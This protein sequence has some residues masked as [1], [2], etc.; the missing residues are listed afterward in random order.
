M[1]IEK[2]S[3]III[4]LTG[5]F[6]SGCSTL[7]KA[8][9]EL[10]FKRFSLSK[11]VKEEW[12]NK[13]KNKN[14]DSAPR[15]ELQN[16]G[17]NLRKRYGYDFLAKE[18]SNR[19]N[20]TVKGKKEKRVVFDSIRNTDEI[21]WLRDNNPN[22]YLIAVDCSRSIRWERIKQKKYY[23][24]GLTESDFEEDDE[25]DKNQ[26]DP[27]GQ[28]VKFGQQ[29]QLCVYEADIIINN[30][31]NYPNEKAAIKKLKDKINKL[32]LERISENGDLKVPIL[33]DINIYTNQV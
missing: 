16:I 7:A 2:N 25:R 17:N 31:D 1:Y 12:Q 21:R 27:F 15:F 33:S 26:E 30:N 14:I 3:T 20:Q 19:A 11:I 22:F 13:N 4:G 6:G 5:S 10:G 29:V 18:I 32:L 24:N 23:E 9:E 28:Q 8:L